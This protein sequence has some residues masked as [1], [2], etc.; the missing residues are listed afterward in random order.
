MRLILTEDRPIAFFYFKLT[1]RY[2]ER[3]K[4]DRQGV[5]KRERE[6]ERERERVRC[7]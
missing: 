1:K 6:R 3:K 2:T 5:R 4:R 7:R